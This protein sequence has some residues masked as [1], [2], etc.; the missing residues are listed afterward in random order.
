[1][2]CSKEKKIGMFGGRRGLAV[3]AGLVLLCSRPACAQ[4]VPGGEAAEALAG[5]FSIINRAASWY[6]QEGGQN[7]DGSLTWEHAE[8]EGREVL[9]MAFSNFRYYAARGELAENRVVALSGDLELGMDDELISGAVTVKGIPQVSSLRFAKFNIYESGS[10]EINGLRYDDDAAEDILDEA[11]YLV[12]DKVIVTPEVEAGI[13]F[14]TMFSAIEG[15]GLSEAVPEDAGG[16]MIIPPGITGSNPQETVKFVT[17]KNA[18]EISFNG[19]EAGGAFFENVSPLFDGK[20]VMDYS[21]KADSM[22]SVV[23][24]GSLRITNTPFISSMG[25]DSCTID[26][27]T[28]DGD[29]SGAI[30]ING[31]SHDFRD[32]IQLMT[33]L[34][35]F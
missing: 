28:S 26:E 9:R 31:A 30:I 27:Q 25:F 11:V 35:A 7:L 22:I 23:F 5:V 15:A 34:D 2:A 20:F 6:G 12:E 29:M 33:V 32:F 21:F 10:L 13:V 1:M 14:L 3:L 19:Y 8:T 24:D 16:G 4:T 17:R 18:F